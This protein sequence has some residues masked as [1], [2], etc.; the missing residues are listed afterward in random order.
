MSEQDNERDKARERWID[1]T[2]RMAEL[3]DEY[4]RLRSGNA[5][6]LVD[7]KDPFLLDD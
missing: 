1:L 5:P 3:D 4:L 2:K 6:L 7:I